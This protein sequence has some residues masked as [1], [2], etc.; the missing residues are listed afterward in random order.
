MCKSLGKVPSDSHPRRQARRINALGHPSR[1]KALPDL[2]GYV[3]VSN[4]YLVLHPRSVA[5]EIPTK[6]TY[7]TQQT[8][9]ELVG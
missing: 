9:G 2:T 6:T 3:V 5:N 4:I 1:L 8:A 7:L